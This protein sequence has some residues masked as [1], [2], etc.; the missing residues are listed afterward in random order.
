MYNKNLCVLIS[1]CDNYSDT[2]EPFFT[3]FFKYW[4]ALPFPVYLSSETRSYN[5]AEV[6]NILSGKNKEWSQRLMEALNKIESKYVLLLLEDYLLY[7]T[8]DTQRIYKLMQVIEETSAAYLRLIPAPEPDV[9][10]PNHKGIGIINK[11]ATYRVSTQAA[12]W[13]RDALLSL[14]VPNESVWQFEYEGT[15]RSNNLPNLFLSLEKNKKNTPYPYPYIPTSIV[16]GKWTHNAVSLC[17]KENIK[18]DLN[19]RKMQT[20]QEHFGINTYFA[21]PKPLQH[22][23]DFILNKIKKRK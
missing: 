16:R 9:S 23:H 10:L 22:L 11:G 13:N 5:H 18:L 4:R 3:L 7:Q 17:R 1:S 8:V 21:L 20:L 2:W 14:L 19:Y 6:K 12:I 15:E